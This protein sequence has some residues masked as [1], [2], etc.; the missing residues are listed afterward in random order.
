MRCRDT[1][2]QASLPF[3]RRAGNVRGAFACEAS[4]AGL[5]IALLDDVMTTGATME[6]LARTLRAAGAADIG[7][8]VLARTP[9]PN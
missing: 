5:R 2:P 1:L 4:V 9:R 7:V 8:W 6:E 3:D